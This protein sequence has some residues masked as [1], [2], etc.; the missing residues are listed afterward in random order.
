MEK[1]CGSMASFYDWIIPAYQQM[2]NSC[3]P[4]DYLHGPD[5]VIHDKTFN[6]RLCPGGPNATA[7]RIWL[8][9]KSEDPIIV[10]S[11]SFYLV[12]TDKSEINIGSK[13]NFTFDKTCTKEDATFQKYVSQQSNILSNGEL[14]I[15]C[16][17]QIESS[18]EKT[19]DNQIQDSSLVDDLSLQFAEQNLSFTDT[20]LSCCGKEIPVHRFMLAARSPVFKAMFSHDETTEGQKG[21]VE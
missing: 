3:F 18:Q 9:K 15:R 6:I 8:N 10:N 13:M 21:K 11:L 7:V 20:I 19:Q 1:Q 4:T 14:R 16:R 2:A 5:F 12:G 17:I